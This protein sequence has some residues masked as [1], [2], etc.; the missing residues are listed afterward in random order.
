MLLLG[1]LKPFLESNDVVGP[2]EQWQSTFELDQMSLL[3]QLMFSEVVWLSQRVLGWLQSCQESN[4]QSREPCESAPNWWHE[5]WLVDVKRIPESVSLVLV[6]IFVCVCLCCLLEKTK[7]EKRRKRVSHE[8]KQKKKQK[9]KIHDKFHFQFSQ[10]TI[11]DHQVVSKHLKFCFLI[12]SFSLLL[13]LLHARLL[14]LMFDS[15]NFFQD[16]CVFVLHFCKLIAFSCCCFVSLSFLSSSSTSRSI[17]SIFCSSCWISVWDCC[18]FCALSF[19]SW[20]VCCCCKVVWFSSSVISLN[21]LCWVDGV[22]ENSIEICDFWLLLLLWVVAVCCLFEEVGRLLKICDLWFF[23]LELVTHSSCFLFGFFFLFC[24]V[25]VR[26]NK[27]KISSE[28]KRYFGQKVEFC[29]INMKLTKQW[30]LLLLTI[31]AATNHLTVYIK[32]E[33]KSCKTKKKEINNSKYS[34]KTKKHH[35]IKNTEN[36][37]KYCKITNTAK[38]KILQKQKNTTKYKTPQTQKHCKK[39]NTTKSKNTTKQKT[40]QI[41]K[42]RKMKKHGK[43]NKNIIKR[44]KNWQKTKKTKIQKK[45]TKKIDKKHRNKTKNYKTKNYKKKKKHRKTKKIHNKKIDTLSNRFCHDPSNSMVVLRHQ[46]ITAL[47]V[48]H[49]APWQPEMRKFSNT[50]SKAVLSTSRQSGNLAI[51]CHCAN[52]VVV[53]I[54]DEHS[55]C[56]VHSEEG[57]KIEAHICALTISITS[58]STTRQ[59]CDNAIRRYLANCVVPSVTNKNHTINTNSNAIRLVEE[60]VCSCSVLVFWFPT[61]SQCCCCTITTHF[62]NAMVLV[63]SDNNHAIRTKSKTKM[64]IKM[65]WRA[66]TISM[67]SLHTPSQRWNHVIWY[68]SNLIVAGV[69]NKHV[70]IIIHHNAW[71]VGE[72]GRMGITIAKSWLA[73]RSASIDHSP[74]LVRLRIQSLKQTATK[75]FPFRSV[76]ICLGQ[77]KRTWSSFPM[78]LP[79][80]AVPA[81]VVTAPI[82]WLIANKNKR[83]GHKKKNKQKRRRGRRRENKHKKQ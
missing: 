60:C 33:S 46:Q 17:L 56:F 26:W 22:V 48:N 10:W 36:T 66:V 57:W 71:G 18:C 9:Q 3:C 62:A 74:A 12:L 45:L 44:V 51:C 20:I 80:S 28:P 29:Q 64:P 42:H 76:V 47:T 81:S 53:R 52:V 70:P 50:I 63:I 30:L 7:T 15:L 34:R 38:Q 1:N 11:W 69:S 65:N 8:N 2:F 6:N 13:L 68:L 43:K 54:R 41:K 5:E 79:C 32:I 35:K 67:T 24:V 75:V 23:C 59:S 78:A 19:A 82:C 4:L 49:H 21:F 31:K 83:N 39:K 72:Q 37:K 40:L 73:R 14:F 27:N 25:F 55:G 58:L 16:I 61:P 77:R